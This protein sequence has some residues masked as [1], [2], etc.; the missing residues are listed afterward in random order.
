MTAQASIDLLRE[1]RDAAVT[2]LETNL[3]RMV[4]TYLKSVRASNPLLAAD[5]EFRARLK[6][7]LESRLQDASR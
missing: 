3:D 1:R 7:E 4:E 5:A 2:R 6:E